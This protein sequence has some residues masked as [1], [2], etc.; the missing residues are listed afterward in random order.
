MTTID[1]TMLLAAAEEFALRGYH[2][3]QLDWILAGDVD[4]L[5]DPPPP[6]QARAGRRRAQ[7]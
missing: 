3:A 2:S 1:D 7:R 6:H 5:A 4:A